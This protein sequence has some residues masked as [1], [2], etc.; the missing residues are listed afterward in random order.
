M[1]S[2]SAYYTLADGSVRSRAG[3]QP[4][5]YPQQEGGPM[6]GLMQAWSSI[7]PNNKSTVVAAAHVLE[8]AMANGDAVGQTL[9]GIPGV[10]N[11]IQQALNPTS[12]QGQL[13]VEII[14]EHPEIFIRLK[15][16]ATDDVD[17][18][19][20]NCGLTPDEKAT[21]K[22]LVEIVNAGPKWGFAE[23]AMLIGALALLA[24]GAFA[25]GSVYGKTH[26][27]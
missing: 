27:K 15:Q 13:L 2:S 3:P 14:R 1:S 4:E 6:Q 24:G 11:T 25:V 22:S 17:A 21:V 26:K 18:L 16:E 5:G 10:C 19:C 20:A 7:G 8:G 9:S 12:P 23:W